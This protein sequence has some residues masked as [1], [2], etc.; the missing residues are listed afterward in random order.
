[1]T[2]SF[3]GRR[4]PVHIVGVSRFY[5]VQLPTINKQLPAFPLEV[6]L[7][8]PNPDLRGGRRECY[9]SAIVAPRSC[10][11]PYLLYCDGVVLWVEKTSTYSWSRCHT[12]NCRPSAS[13]YQ[14]S[15][16]RLGQPTCPLP[17]SFNIRLPPPPPPHFTLDGGWGGCKLCHVF[18]LIAIYPCTAV[19]KAPFDPPRLYKITVQAL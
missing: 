3:V 13:D 18:I 7:P 9:H 6:G 14:L 15:N 16:M 10:L 8:E 4:K 11:V 12:I 5:T 19:P 17:P 2:G 1:M